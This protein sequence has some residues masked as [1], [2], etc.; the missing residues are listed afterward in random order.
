[1]SACY[2]LD[3]RHALLLGRRNHAADANAGLELFIP[4]TSHVWDAPSAGKWVQAIRSR[5]IPTT[6]VNQLL[7]KVDGTNEISCDAF[8]SALIVACYSTSITTQLAN[9][10]GFI[11][12]AHP[13]FEPSH[14]EILTKALIEIPAIQIMHRA[15]QLVSLI[16]F[17]ALIATAGE[18]WFFSRKLAGDATTAAE[19]FKKLKAQLHHWSTS[20][21][22]TTGFIPTGNTSFYNAVAIALQIIQI[23]ASTTNPHTTFSFGPELAVYL[24]AI[25]LWAAAF[26]GL[27]QARASGRGSFSADSDPAE[28]E[29]LRA[30]N[31]VKEFLPHAINDVNRA[32]SNATSPHAQHPQS[33]AIVPGEPTPADHHH[34]QSLVSVTGVSMP[35]M[36][37]VFPLVEA[38]TPY[39]SLA[40]PPPDVLNS[41]L[42]GVGSVLRWTAC[43]LGGSGQRQSGA[44]EMVEGAIGV[45]EKL[46]RGAWVRPWF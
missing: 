39:T 32:L 25:V 43:V 40:F 24:A 27:K 45:L 33:S 11:I 29:P 3:S 15:V 36:T 19:E 38:S 8:Q 28:W 26:A 13:A 5:V 31:L 4:V 16:P 46:G 10:Q 20:S 37:E 9:G 14:Q 30:E 12:P 35:S 23:S 42:T 6:T 21:I 18:S 41:W 34:L 2:I 44:G 17:K 1:V 7:D 22:D